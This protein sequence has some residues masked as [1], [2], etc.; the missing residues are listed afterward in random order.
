MVHITSQ[1]MTP[2]KLANTEV[3]VYSNCEQVELKLNGQS[4][5]VMKPDDIKIC[6]WETIQLQ[7]GLNR[8]EA[9]GRTGG[10]PLTD[11]CEWVLQPVA[12]H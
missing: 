3:K 10:G 9:I 11:T 2:R 8:V 4:M 12:P 1:R 7:P 6:R 5:G